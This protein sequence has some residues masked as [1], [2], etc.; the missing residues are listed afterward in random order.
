MIDAPIGRSGSTRDSCVNVESGLFHL[1][2]EGLRFQGNR[3]ETDHALLTT[4]AGTGVALVTTAGD[5][6]V[7]RDGDTTL[8][9]HNA[10]IGGLGTKDTLPETTVDAE[11]TPH[12]T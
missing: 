11:K 6:A 2:R 3:R 10:V 12:I 8:L 1:N 9:S 5:A 7:E 4:P